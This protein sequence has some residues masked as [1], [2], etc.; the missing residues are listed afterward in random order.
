MF[1]NMPSN[2]PI[3]PTGCHRLLHT[4]PNRVVDLGG[5]AGLLGYAALAWYSQGTTAAPELWAFFALIGWVS[6]PVAMVFAFFWRTPDR[7]P[8]PRLMIWAALFRLCGLFGVPLFEDDWFRY[9]WDGYR[10]METGTPYGFAPAEAFA[11]PSVTPVF[12]R[13]LDQINYP[14]LPTIYGPTTQYAFLASHVLGPGSLVPLQL[15]LIG[16]DLVLI[17]L[18]LSVAPAGFVLLYAW[19]PLVIKEIAFTAHPDGLGVCLLFAAL[20]L[21]RRDRVTGAAACLALA[22]GA[23][24][25][26]LLLAP[27]ILLRAPPRAW[28]AFIGVLGLLYAPFLIQGSSDW[29]ALAIFA[30]TWEFNAALYGL[31]TLWLPPLTAKMALGAGLAALGAAYWL[32]HRRTAAGELPRGDWIFGLFLLAAPV[33]NPWYAVWL[34]PFAALW[35]SWWAWTAAW[36]L[37]LSYVT[38]ANLGA[39]ADLDPF[40]HPVWVRPVEFG[41]IFLALCADAW[42]RYSSQSHQ[43]KRISN[44]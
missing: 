39:V 35:P 15:L 8:I 25:F 38:G 27:F 24:V 17:R 44:G 41:V 34:L 37:L 4:T 43:T 42:R 26:A 5:L 40:A 1:L 21:H 2:Q 14:D 29:A 19:C 20:L 31:L 10:F 7:L 33:I 18:L 6:L 22:V 11:D 12:Q 30:Q 36:A 23:K 28:L 13:L 9:L 32:H 16:V 3:G